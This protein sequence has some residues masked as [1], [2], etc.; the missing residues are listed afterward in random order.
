M[1][2]TLLNR[3]DR[4]END[5]RALRASHARWRAGA[6]AACG[7]AAIGTLAGMAADGVVEVLRARRVELVGE[8]GKVSAQ[9]SAGAH[10]GQIDVWAAGGANVARLAASES[11]GDLSLWN[12][13]GKP[14]AGVYASSGGGRLE[15]SRGDGELAGYLEATPD[16]SDLAMSRAGSENAASRFRVSKDRS[17]ALLAHAE[18]H[19][20]LLF[21]ATPKGAA[22]TVIGDNDREIAYLGGDASKAGLIRLSNAAGASMLEAG[23]G[24]HGGELF[25]RNASGQGGAVLGNVDK[26]GFMEVR[27]ADGKAAASLAVQDNNG[28]RVAAYTA[29]GQI[30]AFM[31]QGKDESGTVQVY[32]GPNR[33]AALGG[34]ATGGLLNLFNLKGKAVFVAGS[35]ADGT[36]GLM[37]I[38]NGDGS[39][40]VRA[41]AEP[42]PEMAVYSTDGQQKRVISAPGKP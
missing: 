31:D 41:S 32:A 20:V 34:S 12:T 13:A 9:M 24:D 27:N 18:A 36:G 16:G 23:T 25:A 29:T 26:G 1:H 5:L 8:D 39:Q 6:L 37:S 28:G 4:L 17:E 2:D 3:I 38:R 22:V 21:G 14:V 35:A 10:G 40:V 15:V 30:A 42:A 19:S 11:G 33:V 7:L